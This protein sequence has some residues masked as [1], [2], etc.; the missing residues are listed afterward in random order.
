MSE[1]EDVEV[2][3]DGPLTA[4]IGIGA[5]ALSIAYLARAAGSGGWLD[6]A[7]MVVLGSR[8]SGCAPGDPGGESPGPRSTEWSTCPATDCSAT[9]G[10]W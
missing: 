1:L 7:L 10:S 3:R 9:A 2:R 6:W 8:A 5:A 4:V